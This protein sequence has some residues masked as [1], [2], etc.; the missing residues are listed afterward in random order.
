MTAL[1]PPSGSQ[2]S[3]VEAIEWINGLLLGSLA[4]GLC[5]LA[6]SFVGYLMLFG[7][8]TIRHGMRVVLGCFILFGAPLIA[9][10]LS[11]AWQSASS[12][13]SEPLVYIPTETR[14]PLPP[15]NYDP[16]AGASLRRD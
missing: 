1:L 5:I 7:Q 13:P 8:I 12:L 9:A 16:Y 11:G 4:T 15:A 10:G 14:E 6:I 2:S 3:F